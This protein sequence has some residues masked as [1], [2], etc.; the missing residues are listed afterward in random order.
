[1]PGGWVD[2]GQT[3]FSNVVKEAREEAGLQVVPER[4]I[5]LQEHNLH[6]GHPFA[7]GIAKAFVLCRSLGGSFS[8][9]AETD[10][11]GFFGPDDLPDLMLAKT[12]PD[13][14]ALCFAAREAGS[15]WECVVD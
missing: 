6:N 3:V 1:M 7:W 10:A 5:A 12:S 15:A 9:N 14:L 13:Q 11:C 4:L 8:E 2:Q